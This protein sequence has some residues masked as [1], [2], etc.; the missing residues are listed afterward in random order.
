MLF[1][2]DLEMCYY[3]NPV[4]LFKYVDFNQICWFYYTSYCDYTTTHKIWSVWNR[5]KPY[6][7]AH[8]DSKRS[9][10]PNI[11]YPLGFLCQNAK[12]SECNKLQFNVAKYTGFC[13][14]PLTFINRYDQT[15][16]QV[17]RNTVMKSA[18]WQCN[19]Y[20]EI[21]WSYFDTDFDFDENDCWKTIWDVWNIAEYEWK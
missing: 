7:L 19:S 15:I 17:L 11:H 4:I 16:D 2:T 13:H 21:Y 12:I 14:S 9:T 3:P 6:W 20:F 18:S 5:S 1:F 10:A 8:A